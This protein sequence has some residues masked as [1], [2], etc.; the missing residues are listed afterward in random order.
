ML[1]IL[2]EFSPELVALKQVKLNLRGIAQN[3]DRGLSRDI[4]VILAQFIRDPVAQK[5]DRGQ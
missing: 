4:L 2:A 3:Y 1:V 5:Q